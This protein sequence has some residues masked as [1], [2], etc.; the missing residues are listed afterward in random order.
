MKMNIDED[1]DSEDEQLLG[2]RQQ[3]PWSRD[4][5]FTC[6]RPQRR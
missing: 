6:R 1:E 5:V 3:P 4:P 2:R